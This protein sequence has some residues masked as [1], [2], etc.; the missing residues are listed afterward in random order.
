MS[1]C[2][3]ELINVLENLQKDERNTEKLKNLVYL[4]FSKVENIIN[5]FTLPKSITGN[6]TTIDCDL[7]DQFY[8][9]LMA[10]DEKINCSEALISAT[11]TVL[12]LIKSDLSVLNID[13]LGI[14]LNP[15]LQYPDHQSL[16]VP[17][18]CYILTKLKPEERLEFQ[19]ITNDSVRST[20]RPNTSFKS[21]APSGK[22]IAYFQSILA[23]L[24]MFINIKILTRDDDDNT[25]AYKDESIVHAAKT[26]EIF[27]VLNEISKFVPYYDF[28]NE[29]IEGT[30]DMKED[31]PRWKGKDGFSFCDC[32]F[33]LGTASKAEILK[34]ECLVH[35]RHEL[36]DSFFRAL[37]IGVN[38]PYLQIE[39][40]RTQVV[41]DTLFQLVGKSTHDLRKQLRVSFVGEEGIDEGGVQKEFFQIIVKD[42][43]NKNYGMFHLQEDS[44][45]HWFSSD[46]LNDPETLQEY[47]LIGRLLGLAIYNGVNLNISFPLAL[48]KKL[49]K[50]PL[51]LDD[52]K[53]I[54]PLLGRGLEQLLKFDGDV[55]ET[56][57]RNFQ[58]EY[59]T[60]SGQRLTIDL[61]ENGENIMV[62]EK[63]R[64]EFVK[65]YINFYF[66]SNVEKQFRAFYEGFNY[67]MEGSAL[68]L[69]RAEELQELVCGSAHLDFEALE[70]VTQYDGYT[71]DDRII[72]D[73][74]ELVHEM[75]EEEKKKLLFFTTGSDRVPVGGLSKLQFVI[76]RNGADSDRLPTSHTCYNVLLLSDYASKQ[77][78]SDRL[79]TALL[80]SNSYLLTLG[81]VLFY[82]YSLKER[83]SFVKQCQATKA[84]QA[85]VNDEVAKEKFASN[86]L[87]SKR[88]PQF[89]KVK[90]CADDDLQLME[91]SEVPKCL[92]NSLI[93]KRNEPDNFIFDNEDEKLILDSYC[94][95]KSKNCAKEIFQL[96][97]S[98]FVDK[99]EYQR[100]AV[101]NESIVPDSDIFEN[102]SHSKF[103]HK[104]P[105]QPTVP[106]Y[107]LNI[108]VKEKKFDYLKKGIEDVSVFVSYLERFHIE[109]I[110][111]SI[112]DSD[113]N[114]NERNSKLNW[115]KLFIMVNPATLIDFDA[116]VGSLAFSKDYFYN[117]K[118]QFEK[119]AS[120][121]LLAL[122]VKAGRVIY[123]EQINSSVKY[124]YLPAVKGSFF[125]NFRSF[126]VNKRELSKDKNIFSF[127]GKVYSIQ[128]V[129]HVLISKCHICDNIK[130][131]DQNFCNFKYNEENHGI[132]NFIK[133][134]SEGSVLQNKTKNSQ[135]FFQLAC[136]SCGKLSAEALTDRCYKLE[137]VMEI[138]NMEIDHCFTNV[139]VIQVILE[140][141]LV[142]FAQLGDHVQVFGT[143]E[144]KWNMR[145]STTSP[146]MYGSSFRAENAI[147]VS[148]LQEPHTKEEFSVLPES[149]QNL[150]SRKIIF[151]IERK[152]NFVVNLSPCSFSRKL[153]ESLRYYTVLHVDEVEINSLTVVKLN[154]F[155]F[156]YVLLLIPSRL[157]S[158]PSIPVSSSNAKKSINVLL[159]SEDVPLIKRFVEKV[160]K[161]RKFTEWLPNN[162]LKFEPLIK[163]NNDNKV[164]PANDK[165]EETII[166]TPLVEAKDGI[167]YCLI[168]L[169][170]KC[171]V[172]CLLDAV[173]KKN[174]SFFDN[175]E[176][177]NLSSI[178][179]F[180]FV[181][182][183]CILMNSSDST[184]NNFPKSVT[185]IK[186]GLKDD[187]KRIFEPL[188]GK[189][190]IAINLIS[191][192][193]IKFDH[194]KSTAILLRELN[195]QSF[196]NTIDEQDFQKFVNVASNIEVSLS[197]EAEEILSS[198][199]SALRKLH[200]VVIVSGSD[201]MYTTL[202]SLIRITKAHSRLCLRNVALVDDAVIAINLVE[203]SM[204]L[205]TGVSLNGF[206]SFPDD[207][208][209]IDFLYKKS[210][211]DCNSFQENLFYENMLENEI[212]PDDLPMFKY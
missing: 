201:S 208:S 19:S 40:R 44:R 153:I 181:L 67:V 184:K 74:W 87:D 3:Y 25:P 164:N 79:S 188:L 51:N 80:N 204:A 147:K 49:L 132:V 68:S 203:E 109:D 113:K 160:G 84:L 115:Y 32:P 124:L 9:T 61:K 212:P 43:F 210:S 92:K 13:H 110:K 91:P 48:Y 27:Y 101:L 39:V 211:G 64:T 118:H 93:L 112:L 103:A 183:G 157:V 156:S 121:I 107:T 100:S 169:L 99:D 46:Y 187:V 18:I 69:F 177:N 30:L 37:F 62:N 94:L 1:S 163:I 119:A 35:M 200:G 98:D 158:T 136:F 15:Y 166:S 8:H 192:T 23:L 21:E 47:N 180:N 34:V 168:D 89:Q 33:L 82:M 138:S 81:L 174:F 108:N 90:K 4:T 125:K 31:Y 199:F 175:N 170:K 185:D 117:I 63:N 128:K 179:N 54:D 52:L 182:W 24:Q 83:F 88:S 134:N 66:N 151:P 105:F 53:E 116:K 77:K 140:D 209:N 197:P 143:I 206:H 144:K 59:V 120:S 145:K 10:S 194:Q 123:L 111:K 139:L 14:F 161:L 36:Q 152:L 129:K 135:S 205:L 130:C 60:P 126:E 189:F 196:R 122:C 207:Q 141:N 114:K 142:N 96:E 155:P 131:R 159:F 57:N 71:K 58:V 38:S 28:Y 12:E 198:Y 11:S 148:Y 171:D 154:I 45:L 42:M 172:K 50:F 73:F 137:Q 133:R 202:D 195:S 7:V 86:I 56:F 26:L 173:E 20:R 149:I 127:V 85:E 106:N 176:D 102:T 2:S 186:S 75:T 146:L 22:A 78:L 72:K 6:S 167:L 17:Q 65:L 191:S 55:E 97:T 41:R 190:D 70:N 150:V 76:A 162:F 95:K 5:T 193:D 16:I 104:L 165:I 178:V 29:T